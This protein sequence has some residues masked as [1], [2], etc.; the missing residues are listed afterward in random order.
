MAHVQH[1][2][3]GAPLHVRWQQ[4]QERLEIGR[5]E[6]LGGRELPARGGWW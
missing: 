4:F 1:V 5:V 3:Q 6:L 2:A